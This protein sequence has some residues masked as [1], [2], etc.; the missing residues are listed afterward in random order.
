MH[1]IDWAI[2]V[3]PIAVCGCIAVYTHRYVRSVSDFMAGGRAAGRFLICTARSEQGA[4]AVNYVATFQTFLVAGF[5]VG[6]WGHLTVPISLVLSITGYVIYRYRQTRAM[7]LGQFFE[8]RYSRRYRL[9][10][11]MLGFF[12]GLVNFG[13]IPVIGAKFMVV[14]L[15]L[16][17]SYQFAG[18]AVPT[19]LIL[20][21]LFLTICVIMTTTGGQISVLLTDC[22]EG[23][24]S[25]VFYTVIAIVLLLF[26]FKWSVTR[27]VLLSGPPGQSLVNPFDTKNTKDFNIYFIAMGVILGIYRTMAWQNSHAFN[28]SASSPHESRMG[29]ILGRWRGFAQGVMITLLSVCAL[30]YMKSPEGQIHVAAAMNRITDPASR[31]QM[32]APIALTQMLPVGVKGLLL[33]VCLMGI[34]A[35]DGI[36]LHSWGS[37]FIQDCLMPFRKTPMSPKQHILYLRLA[38]LGVA[39]WA[40]AFGALFPQFKYVQFWW[41]AT[42]SIFVSGAGIAI[43]GGLYWSR[44]NTT[45]AWTGVC[46]GSLVAMTGIGFQAYN[47]KWLGHDFITYGFA[48]NGQKIAFAAF[49]CA[50]SSY[51]AASL[52]FSTKSHNM[53]RLLHRGAYAVE[54]DFVPVKNRARRNWLVRVITF[55]ID[56]QF[57]R[58]DRWITIGITLWSMAWFVTAT[59]LTSVYLIAWKAN[60]TPPWTDVGWADFYLVTGIYL[61]L[62]IGVATTVW[63]TIGCWKDIKDF[64]RKLGEERIDI[65]DDGSVSHEQENEDPVLATIP[66][67]SDVGVL[68]TMVPETHRE[69]KLPG[70][71]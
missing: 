50:V 7:T 63:F 27:E 17:Q 36:H 37:I 58:T 62:A 34:I 5:T 40:F 55:G 22:A 18:Y 28:A 68:P 44:G 19:H 65:H 39:L 15:G 12:A 45:G 71:R 35:G 52:L 13:V 14:F 48:W 46:V 53:D 56:E 11:G 9:A 25:Q 57:T 33:S 49:L 32:K 31:E 61:P 23:M 60:G 38:I 1:W 4:G 70:P 8:M 3:L 20:M 59:V 54:G 41:S 10:M 21:G 2:M 30:T 16:E 24:F 66:A 69:E 51:I 26:F 42:E 47:E 43:I 67:A 29:G 6:W 64:F